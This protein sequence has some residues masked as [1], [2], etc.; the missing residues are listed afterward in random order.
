MN[1]RRLAEGQGIIQ[2]G[3]R[4]AYL[5]D[6]T[7]QIRARGEGSYLFNYE[8]PGANDIAALTDQDVVIIED[9][10]NNE[11]RALVVC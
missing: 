11:F 8:Q 10:E 1:P 9:W 6:G 4:E 5:I 2:R 3:L 7:G